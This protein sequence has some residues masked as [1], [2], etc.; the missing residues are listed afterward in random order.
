MISL[1]LSQGINDS[2]AK[3]SFKKVF[4]SMAVF[5]IASCYAFEYSKSIAEEVGSS[6]SAFTTWNPNARLCGVFILCERKGSDPDA[7]LFT[8]TTKFVYP[9]TSGL[10]TTKSVTGSAT[11]AGSRTNHACLWPFAKENFYKLC[12]YYERRHACSSGQVEVKRSD[13]MVLY[14]CQQAYDAHTVQFCM[15]HRPRNCCRIHAIRDPVA[16]TS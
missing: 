12:T 10:C 4:T 15:Y 16:N 7:K 9:R 1:Y 5:I 6:T 3:M 2:T 11:P 14:T 8:S 13:G